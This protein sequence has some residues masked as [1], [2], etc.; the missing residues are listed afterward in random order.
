MR[1]NIRKSI[2]AVGVAAF[3]IMA[4]PFAAFARVDVSISIPLFDLFGIVV[5]PSYGYAPDYGYAPA[6]G[7][8]AAPPAPAGAV[9]YGGY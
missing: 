2:I 5:A 3:L 4:V 8:Y 6:P 1:T 7:G 9:F